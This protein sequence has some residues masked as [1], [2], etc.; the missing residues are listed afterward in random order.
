MGG[1]TGWIL[2]T[3]GGG[4][5]GKNCHDTEKTIIYH[6]IGALINQNVLFD[7]HKG[8]G[9]SSKI[10]RYSIKNPEVKQIF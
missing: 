3:E 7:A 9:I 10:S 6:L 8:T 5:C 1:I 4:Y 2:G